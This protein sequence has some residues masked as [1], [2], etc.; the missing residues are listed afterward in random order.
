[1]TCFE[2]YAVAWRIDGGGDEG[3]KFGI[4]VRRFCNYLG[5]RRDDRRERWRRYRILVIV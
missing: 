4:L 3:A 1:M 2:K 5:R